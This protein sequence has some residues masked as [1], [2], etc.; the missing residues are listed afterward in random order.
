MTVEETNILIEKAKTRKDGVY[1]YNGNFW[2]VKNN[3][4]V[5]FVSPYGECFQCLGSF[6]VKIGECKES[7]LRKDKLKELLKKM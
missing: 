4:F 5:A 7:Y 3:C 2:A 6:N 1:Q